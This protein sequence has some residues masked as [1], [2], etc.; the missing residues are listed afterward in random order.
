MYTLMYIEDFFSRGHIYTS[1]A[2]VAVVYKKLIFKLYIRRNK[3]LIIGAI[4]NV[5]YNIKIMF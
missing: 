2:D 3:V 1:V 5:L 4:K